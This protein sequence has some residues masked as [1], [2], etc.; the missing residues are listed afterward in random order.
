MITREE[1]GVWV[2]LEETIAVHHDEVF[3]CLTT[4]SGLTRWFC[5]SAEIDLRQG[6]LLVFGWDEKM[7]RTTTVAILEYDPGG[8]IVWD[9]YAEH[10]QTHAPVYWTVQPSVEEGSNVTLR[11]GPFKTEPDALLVMADEAQMWRWYLCNM[12]SAFE[13]KLDMRK[14]KP[15]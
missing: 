6:G 13:A 11:Q 9:W 3:S 14:I 15:L 8:R 12:R 5:V 2:T 10:G 7:T 4:P 1:D